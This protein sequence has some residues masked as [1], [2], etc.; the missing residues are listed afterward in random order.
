MA[1]TEI[2]YKIIYQA[3]TGTPATYDEIA[4][5]NFFD[6]P[7]AAAVAAAVAATPTEITT[8]KTA[9]KTLLEK[10]DSNIVKEFI[11]QL[12]I[13][14][15]KNST[16]KFDTTTEPFIFA[17]DNTN[18]DK[19]QR[20]YLHFPVASALADLKVNF[21]QYSVDTLFN[22]DNVSAIFNNILIT[23]KYSDYTALT[24]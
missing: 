10:Q 18:G 11:K 5:E 4:F 20:T 23:M 19:V 7:V 2:K 13:V 21:Y 15:G 6:G 17:I 22:V 24:A 12:I 8:F 14:A 9:L 16:K 3:T 1:T